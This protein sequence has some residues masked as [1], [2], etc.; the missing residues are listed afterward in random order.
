MS[1]RY[2]PTGPRGSRDY[3]SEPRGDRRVPRGD[4]YRDSYQ[5]VRDR[6]DRRDRHDGPSSY[7]N[8][9]RQ[10]DEPDRDR[11]SWDSRGPRE[12]Y[13]R[14]GE[15]DQ[16]RPYDRDVPSGDK[17]R[18]PPSGPAA[19]RRPPAGPAGA[20]TG[21]AGAPTG[22]AGAPSGPAGA[23]TGPAAIRAPPP[24][25]KAPPS[26]PKATTGPKASTGPKVPPK[27]T[28]RPPKRAPRK[29]APHQLYSVQTSMPEIYKRTQQVGEGT[30][31]K[32]YKAVNQVTHEFVALKRLRLESEREG[33][34]ITAIR[35]IKLL[36]SFDHPNIVSLYE[37][38]VEHHQVYMIFDYC[39]HDLMGLLSHPEIELEE[40]HRKFLF[41]QLM[42]G[43]NYLHKKRVIH[44]D[45]KGSNIL[46][47][48]SGQIKIADFGLARTMKI[49]NDGESPD[50]TN[51]VI[52]IWYRPPEL[53][54]GATDYGQEIDVWGV[55]CLL[56]EL[57]S[58]TAVFK[59]FDEVSQLCK[60]YNVM[61]TPSVEEW[62]QIT[63]LPW[64][65]MLTPKVVKESAFARLYEQM[66]TPGSF[67]LAKQLL[68][69]NPAK[70]ITAA[71]ALAHPWFADEPE[72]APLTFLK[73]VQGEWHEFESK[74][75]RRKEKKRLEDEARARKHDDTTATTT[76]APPTA[77]A[78]DKSAPNSTSMSVGSPLTMV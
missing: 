26:G 36:Q 73:D 72:P 45:I 19:K 10:R 44:R 53:L 35:E 54:L 1:D 58:K 64:F 15:R 78:P 41:R 5:P 39:D 28:A 37:M 13:R 11:D 46:L 40:S 59:G 60:I 42:E 21:P 9:R 32:V 70:R 38:M 56:V 2:R 17:R 34:P 76:P 48:A 14:R 67:A 30:Y 61:G 69:M 18:A 68:E 52:T 62:P 4:S 8:Y 43:L 12:P 55:G 29:L 3:N 51:R 50:Y 66:M 75:R 25:P 16:Y 7:D 74:K 47:D 27:P 33:F 77:P 65:D 23:P 63:N 6:A 20:P 22:P 57:Y 71:E 24:G 31:G 49:V